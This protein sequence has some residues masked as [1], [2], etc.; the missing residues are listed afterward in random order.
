[1]QMTP[2]LTPASLDAGGQHR[3]RRVTLSRARI[4]WWTSE[5]TYKRQFAR[6]TTCAACCP[7]TVLHLTAMTIPL[8]DHGCSLHLTS[9][10]ARRCG[11]RLAKVTPRSG[12]PNLALTTTIHR[13][14]NM[15]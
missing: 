3:T 8:R 10:L 14:L 5:D 12:S 7:A 6:L 4:R 1:V 15:R 9:R 2:W 13:R 11:L